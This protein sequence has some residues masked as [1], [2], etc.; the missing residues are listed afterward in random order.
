MTAGKAYQFATAGA[1]VAQYLIYMM[2]V[3]K[4]WQDTRSFAKDSSRKSH[5]AAE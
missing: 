5:G 2:F 1:F 4:S 3:V